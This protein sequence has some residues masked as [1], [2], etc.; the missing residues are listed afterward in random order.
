MCVDV[1]VAGDEDD[2][3]GVYFQFMGITRQSTRFHKPSLSTIET[4]F[5][6]VIVSC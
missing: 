1:R 6:I 4:W 5:S 3:L 2:V